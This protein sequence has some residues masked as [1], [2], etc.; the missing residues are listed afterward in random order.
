MTPPTIWE[1]VG[2]YCEELAT[3]AGPLLSAIS[4][5]AKA[6]DRAGQPKALKAQVNLN[7]SYDNDI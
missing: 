4:D 6:V 7:A 5:T 3:V 2:D 1:T